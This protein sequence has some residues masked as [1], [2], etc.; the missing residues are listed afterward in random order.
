M[1]FI[2]K[3]DP[4]GDY[5]H[6]DQRVRLLIIADNAKVQAPPSVTIYE[7]VDLATLKTEQGITDAIPA[8]PVIT[9]SPAQ[10]AYDAAK[11]VFGTLTP[12]KQALW[13]PTRA[14]V[15]SA[16]LK[17]DFAAAK[18]ILQTTPAIYDGAEADRELFLSLFP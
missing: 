5:L 17:G 11:A 13:E 1:R 9:P 14:A 18:N 15:S 16:L 8:R 10:L 2:I 3:T 6:L 12:G 4:N 7:A